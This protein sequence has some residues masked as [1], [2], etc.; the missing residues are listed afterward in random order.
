MV[1]Y[2]ADKIVI[3]TGSPASHLS[4][5]NNLKM[6]EKMHISMIPFTPSLV[7][8]KTKPVFKVLKGQRSKGNCNAL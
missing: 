6:L 4:G 2:Q 5:Q 7:Q 1:N 3:A 8:V